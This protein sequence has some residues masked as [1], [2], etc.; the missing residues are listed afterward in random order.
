MDFA[1]RLREQITRYRPEY[2]GPL[3]EFQ[4]EMFGA[5]FRLADTEH[6]Q[7]LFERNP[8]HEKGILPV[9]LFMKDGRVVGQ[10]CAIPTELNIGNQM[11]RASWAVDLMVRPEWRLKGV[12]PA[13]SETCASENAIIAAIGITD[14]AYK[15]FLRAGWID[16][17][18]V[19]EFVLPVDVASIMRVR[20]YNRWL[21]MLAGPAAGWLLRMKHRVLMPWVCPRKAATQLVVAFDARVDRLWSEV[22]EHYP[23]IA[24]RDWTALQ[25]RFDSVPDPSRYY[26][27]YL[28]EQDQLRGYAVV[29]MSTRH[30]LPVAVIVDYLAS[31]KWQMPLIASCIQQ[32]GSKVAAIYCSTLNTAFQSSLRMLGF[33]HSSE[34]PR[35]M[36]R[37]Q[38]GYERLRTVLADRQNWF[39]TKADSDSE[40]WS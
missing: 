28:L 21:T 20:S 12:G 38:D 32:L 39:L 25:W 2:R 1:V 19:P 30:D 11:H 8:F 10:Q 3:V 17:G 22:K 16:L 29:H 27:F 40:F 6:F 31:P 33:L 7:W 18:H 35:F 36:L 5:E 34:G 13:L 24:R 9:W 15:T 14:P 37:H 4:R 26:R 23:V